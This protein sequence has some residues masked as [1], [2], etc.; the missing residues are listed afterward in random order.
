MLHEYLDAYDLD[1]D[2]EVTDR[3]GVHA[4]KDWMSFKTE[5]N[6][7]RVCPE[8]VDL[9]DKLLR[10]DPAARILPKEAMQHPFFKSVRE[11]E[12]KAGKKK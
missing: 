3:L 11:Q 8:V 2:P 4:R 9:I 7:E 1:P 6:K 10:Y 12:A 5:D